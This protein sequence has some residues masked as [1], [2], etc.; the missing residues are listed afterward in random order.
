MEVLKDKK[1]GGNYVLA[2]SDCASDEI[3]EVNA[4]SLC[5]LRSGCRKHA[6]DFTVCR[7]RFSST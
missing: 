5:T 2:L 3:L 7:L 4:Q 6:G 1:K